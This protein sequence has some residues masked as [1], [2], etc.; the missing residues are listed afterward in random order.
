MRHHQLMKDKISAVN[1]KHEYNIATP[2]HEVT[3]VKTRYL[4]N[5]HKC[6]KLSTFLRI[7]FTLFEI[8]KLKNFLFEISTIHIDKNENG[9]CS[10]FSSVRSKAGKNVFL[11]RMKQTACIFFQKKHVCLFFIVS[12]FFWQK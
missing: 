7:L 9:T 6:K 12:S 1:N 10:Q 2:L 5:C 11:M 4:A 3:T 8:S